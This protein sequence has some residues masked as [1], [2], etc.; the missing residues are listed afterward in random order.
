[1]LRIGT[2]RSPLAMWQASYVRDALLTDHPNIEI[3]LVGISTQGDQTLG[4][5]LSS[6]GGKGLFL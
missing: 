1:M 3:E 4:V 6:K 2:R 5:P